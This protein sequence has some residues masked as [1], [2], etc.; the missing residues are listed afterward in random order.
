M[1][2]SAFQVSQAELS[3]LSPSS[4]VLATR[5][6]QPLLPRPVYTCQESP[7]S[8]CCACRQSEWGLCRPQSGLLTWHSSAST[9]DGLL[10]PFVVI[11]LSLYTFC[12]YPLGPLDVLSL[13]VLSSTFRHRTREKSHFME[14]RGKTVYWALKISSEYETTFE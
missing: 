14:C 2:G 8:S 4:Q 11:R 13:Y 3:T 12:C 10:I 7:T 6:W 5:P 1:K 9:A